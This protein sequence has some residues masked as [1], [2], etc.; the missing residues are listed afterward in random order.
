MSDQ[1][2]YPITP[3]I[4]KP[5]SKITVPTGGKDVVYIR[6]DIVDGLVE[7]L[8]SILNYWNRDT[9]P[10]PMF[11]ALLHTI[12]AAD[13]ALRDFNDALEKQK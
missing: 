13:S 10:D 3:L 1:K 12:G 11:D 9:N 7:S 6:S 8:G 4:D 5:Y 2:L